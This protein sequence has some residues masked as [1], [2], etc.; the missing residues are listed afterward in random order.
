MQYASFIRE[1]THGSA[2]VPGG[3]VNGYYVRGLWNEA[4]TAHFGL[5]DLARRTVPML[6]A[7]CG[8]APFVSAFS[9]TTNTYILVVYNILAGA[10]RRQGCHSN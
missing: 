8:V 2:C 4:S 10:C 6:H 9:Q 3:Q 5:L 7:C 1:T